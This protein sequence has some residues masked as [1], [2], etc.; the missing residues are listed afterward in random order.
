LALG[1]GERVGHVDCRGVDKVR[2]RKWPRTLPF[3]F[4][5][6]TRCSKEEGDAGLGDWE[7]RGG[8]CSSENAGS[9]SGGEDSVIAQV[10]VRRGQRLHHGGLRGFHITGSCTMRFGDSLSRHEEAVM[11]VHTYQMRE[12][13][14]LK[15]GG[16]ETRY[17]AASLQ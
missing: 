9:G 12:Q 16:E 2:R 7:M 5:L 13:G 14:M 17:T 11:I 4:G 6:G 15:P 10:V 8:P 3:D 1:M